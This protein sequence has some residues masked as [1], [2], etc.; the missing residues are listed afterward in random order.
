MKY[1][2]K[3]QVEIMGLL[4]IIILITI[5]LILGLRLIGAENDVDPKKEFAQSQLASNTLS[6]LLKSTSRDCSGFSMTEILQDCS[7]NQDIICGDDTNSCDYF[8]EITQ[9][10]FGETLDKWNINY[11]F[12]IFY[13]KEDPLFTLG[14]TCIENKKS[15]LFPIPTSSG[16]LNVKMDIC[17]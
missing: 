17:V 10:I 16:I 8:I 9:Q 5:S 15:R 14:R 7:Q 6:T 1:Q 13:K 2:L 11:E 3:G 12:K 4:M